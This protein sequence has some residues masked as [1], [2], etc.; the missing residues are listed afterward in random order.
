MRA[1]NI[2]PADVL[3]FLADSMA[4][5]HAEA[6]ANAVAAHWRNKN[7]SFS[8]APFRIGG[9]TFLK[10]LCKQHAPRYDFSVPSTRNASDA[11]TKKNKKE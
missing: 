9:C 3:L 5:R 4:A 1:H 10:N 8:F 11:T 7:K 2:T 6:V